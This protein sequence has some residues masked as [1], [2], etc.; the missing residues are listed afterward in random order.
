[1]SEC[2]KLQIIVPHDC[3]AGTKMQTLV[4]KMPVVANLKPKEVT[5]EVI[6]AESNK[7]SLVQVY[8]T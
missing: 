2:V 8:L 5:I 3:P 6:P 1:M 7:F 4:K